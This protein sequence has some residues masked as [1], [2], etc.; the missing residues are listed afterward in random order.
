MASAYIYYKVA[1]NDFVAATAIVT[2]FQDEV[3]RGGIAYP[4]GLM[5]RPG[6]STDD[7]VT[8]M[9]IYRLPGDD[10]FAQRQSGAA[11][12]IIRLREGPLELRTLLRGERQVEVF[13]PVKPVR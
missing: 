1:Q 12:T 7:E 11:A 3:D 2:I 4:L 9:E 8:L 13:E 10:P 6:S 5:R